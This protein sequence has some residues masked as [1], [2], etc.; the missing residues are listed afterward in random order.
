MKRNFAVAIFV[1]AITIAADADYRQFAEIAEDPALTAQ[2]AQ[3]SAELLTEFAPVKLTADNLSMTLIDLSGETPRRGS[4]QGGLKMYP[5]SVV[6]LFFLTVAYD[7]LEHGKLTMSPELQRALKDMIVE[8]SNDATAYV[9]DRITRTTSGEEL[10]GWR[11]RRFMDRRKTVNR[12]FD[13]HGYDISGMLKAW[14][15]GPYG[16]DKFALGPDRINRNRMTSDQ[17]AALMLDIETRRNVS[18]AASE[19]MLKLM[20]RT[21]TADGGTDSQVKEFTGESLPAGSKLWSKAGWTSEVRHDATYVE[22]PNGKR[23]ILV[24]CTRGNEAAVDVTLLPAAG[25]KIASLFQK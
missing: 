2:L 18:A 23:Y 13:S 21:V 5:A 3:V 9:V 15:E 24:V 10:T 11:M 16:R 6:K 12:Y 25:R 17:V 19:A 22:L 7:Q 20:R 4:F 14:C 1:L 8:S